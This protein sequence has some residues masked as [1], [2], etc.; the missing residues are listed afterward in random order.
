MKHEESMHDLTHP[1]LTI[2]AGTRMV[3]R[4]T[5]RDAAGAGSACRRRGWIDPLPVPMRLDLGV[6]QI[7]NPH[8]D[9]VGRYCA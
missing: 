6:D 4:V 3:A 8:L 5:M 2:R 7:A 9:E 1:A